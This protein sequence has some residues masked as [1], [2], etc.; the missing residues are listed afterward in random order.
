M[1]A[2]F[3]SIMTNGC[4]IVKRC[5]AEREGEGGERGVGSRREDKGSGGKR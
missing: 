1:F 5:K 4:D 3:K 2:G